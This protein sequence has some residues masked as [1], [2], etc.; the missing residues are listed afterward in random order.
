MTVNQKRCSKC[1]EVKPVDDF[2]KNATKKDGRQM[3]CK[4]CLRVRNQ[5][6]RGD[7]P[8]RT[9]ENA[10]K[11]YADNPEPRRK[12]LYEWRKENPKKVLAAS[13]KWRKANPEVMRG[14][15][16]KRYVVNPQ[17]TRSAVVKLV[18]NNYTNL[19]AMFGPACVECGWELPPQVFEYHHL[20]PATKNGALSMHWGWKRVKA[21]VERGVVQLCPTCHRLRHHNEREKQREGALP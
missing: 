4:N 6:W 8:E 1:G 2:W 16:R 19:R 10:N 7:H 5:V 13:R 18:N 11:R 3:Y 21:Y 17:R 12:Q 9:R 15:D 14:H 20:D